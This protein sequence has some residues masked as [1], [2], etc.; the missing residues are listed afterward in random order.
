[1]KQQQYGS[2]TKVFR[3]FVYI[4]NYLGKKYDL[5]IFLNNEDKHK[6]QF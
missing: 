1:M 2:V 4:C 6:T 5:Q 3:C